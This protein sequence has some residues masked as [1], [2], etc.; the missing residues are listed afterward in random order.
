ME[1]LTILRRCCALAVVS[2]ALAV[3]SAPAAAF[4]ATEVQKLLAGDGSSWDEFG[5]AVA[6]EGDTALIS[7]RNDESAYVF[8]REGNGSWT[9]QAKLT[10]A[11]S[12]FG[13]SVAVE[14]DTA[15]VLVVETRNT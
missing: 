4:T 14:D 13:W 2:A 10:A 3:L 5:Y 12:G 9:Q 15:V 6:V 8:I 7:A 1:L 11:G